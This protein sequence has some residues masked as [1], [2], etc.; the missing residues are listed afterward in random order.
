MRLVLFG[1]C[2]FKEQKHD[3]LGNDC[4]VFVFGQKSIDMYIPYILKWISFEI[5]PGDS[6]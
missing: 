5:A 2:S 3:H 6:G 4:D 1:G